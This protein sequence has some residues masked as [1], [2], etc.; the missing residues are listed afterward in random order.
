MRQTLSKVFLPVTF[1]A[2]TCLVAICL[3]AC[4][5]DPE[6]GPET[7]VQ[8]EIDGSGIPETPEQDEIDGSGIPETPAQDETDGSELPETREENAIIGS[9]IDAYYD[10]S[11]AGI[12]IRWMNPDDGSYSLL[13]K[14]EGSSEWNIYYGGHREDAAPVEYELFNLSGTEALVGLFVQHDVDGRVLEEHSEFTIDLSTVVLV[15][16]EQYPIDG[17]EI[18]AFYEVSS[19]GIVIGWNNP[20]DGN[21]T[22]SLRTENSLEWDI[23]N[24]GHGEEKARVDF[25]LLNLSG[26]ETLVGQFQKYGKDRSFL[27]GYS[28][29]KIDLSTVEFP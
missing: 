8:D 14:T 7:P 6:T 13:L 18:G 19:D 21:Y 9:G 10:I 23:Y 5:D 4:S 20:V 22:L 2:L 29:F 27:Q 25:D 17:S 1:S 3:V 12:D 26:L 16:P 15:T 11:K 28:E 24:G